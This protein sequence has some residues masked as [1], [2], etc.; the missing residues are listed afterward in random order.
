MTN[1]YRDH[2]IILCEDYINEE[3]ARGF[4]QNLD[5]SSM[6]NIRFERIAKGWN[7]CFRKLNDDY[8]P[9]LDKLSARYLLIIMDFDSSYNDRHETF[10]KLF[11]NKMDIHKRVFLIGSAI[12]PEVLKQRLALSG[13]ND[14][15]GSKLFDDCNSTELNLW[16]SDEL[17]HNQDEIVRLKETTKSF[18]NWDNH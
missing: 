7:K 17:A 13:K 10:M 5:Q 14:I 18:I 15:V 3:I 8:I 9:E 16:N 12:E 1:K 2:L 6:N 4:V 11:E